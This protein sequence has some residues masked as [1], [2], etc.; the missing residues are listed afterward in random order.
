MNWDVVE[1]N[2]IQLKSPMRSHWWKVTGDQLDQIQGNRDACKSKLRELY[3][4]TECEAEI[5][6]QLFQSQNKDFKPWILT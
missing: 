2:W 5:K 1:E 4:I 3:G 6:I